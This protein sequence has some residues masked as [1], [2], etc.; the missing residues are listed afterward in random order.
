MPRSEKA[1]IQ[2]EG[3]RNGSTPDDIP[4]GFISWDE[5]N[6]AWGEFN[7]RDRS[8]LSAN[9]IENMGGFSYRQV[10]ELLGH[11]PVSWEL[12]DP[13]RYALFL[14]APED[15]PP[16]LTRPQVMIEP[17]AM[18]S[19]IRDSFEKPIC[20]GDDDAPD[21]PFFFD[22][23]EGEHCPR[24]FTKMQAWLNWWVDAGKKTTTG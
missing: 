23:A 2:G 16:D 5:H 3:R 15:G 4:D 8:G 21:G 14:L 22:A 6:L 10:A 7:R 9:E 18:R 1:Q 12:R 19:H 17:P 11:N 24:C 20:N 13:I